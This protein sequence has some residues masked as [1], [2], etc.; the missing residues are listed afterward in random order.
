MLM[1]MESAAFAKTTSKS[2]SASR[3]VQTLFK[4]SKMSQKCQIF[5]QKSRKILN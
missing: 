4:N 5:I 1:G 3:L 2:V